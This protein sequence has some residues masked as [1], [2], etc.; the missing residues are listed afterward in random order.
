[1]SGP[2]VN[3]DLWAVC[4]LG[5]GGAVLGLAGLLAAAFRK[6]GFWK[7]AQLLAGGTAAAVAAA[8]ELRGQPP[9]ISL[10]PLALAAVCLAAWLLAS[11]RFSRVATWGLGRLRTPAVQAGLLLVTGPAATGWWASLNADDPT[12]TFKELSDDFP[13]FFQNTPDLAPVSDVHAYTDRG[14]PVRLHRCLNRPFRD[15]VFE[16]RQAAYLRRSGLSER[17]LL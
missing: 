4:W 16:E 8:A 11:A 10:P 15:D 12:P 13:E 6:P 3:V 17:V 14:R 1:M 7:A 5:A 9:G 2:W